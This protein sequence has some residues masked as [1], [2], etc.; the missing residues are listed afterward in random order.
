MIG[1]KPSRPTVYDYISL[2]KTTSPVKFGVEPRIDVPQ[3]E[4]K[5]GGYQETSGNCAQ[6][7]LLALEEQF[8]LGRLSALKAATVMPGIVLT[9]QI[10][11]AV[12]GTLMAVGMPTGGRI[13]MTGRGTSEHLGQLEDSVG[14][15]KKSLAA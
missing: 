4:R 6:R 2:L 3:P 5:P 14:A 9:G 7:T 1:I 15:S 11:G 8:H 12:V 13:W 10:C